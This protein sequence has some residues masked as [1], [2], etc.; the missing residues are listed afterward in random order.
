MVSKGSFVRITYVG[1][2]KETGELFDTTDAEIAKKEGVF[3]PKMKYG[4]VMIV[5]GEGKLVRGL[6]EVL[7]EMKAGDE[8]ALDIPPEKAFGPRSADLMRLVPLQEFKK[9]GFLPQQ[10]MPI[11]MNGLRGRVLSVS[12]GRVRVDFNHPLAGK[13]LAYTVRI[14][15]QVED[16]QRQAQGL[17]DFYAMDAKV[18]LAGT[19]AEVFHEQELSPRTKKQLTDEL[20]RHVG[21]ADVKFV[22]PEKPKE[23]QA[24]EKAA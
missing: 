19:G 12:G 22:Q 16:K 6:D 7:A 14:E 20:K 23:A 1:R 15:E 24:T 8:R 13:A 21:V 2:I 4:P 10:G 5:V 11:T 3:N 17:C 9:Q 18:T